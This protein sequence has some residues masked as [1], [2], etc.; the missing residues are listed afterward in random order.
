MSSSSWL[1]VKVGVGGAGG[2]TWGV[3]WAGFGVMGGAWRRGSD[4]A[5]WGG[6]CICGGGGSKLGFTPWN[7]PILPNWKLGWMGNRMR[8]GV[9]L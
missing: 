2:V 4:R 7:I 6:I 9:K 1:K 3:E 5:G 8:S